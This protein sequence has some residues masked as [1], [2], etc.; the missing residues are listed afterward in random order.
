MREIPK[1]L[2]GEADSFSNDHLTYGS[3]TLR[4]E[5]WITAD[6]VTRTYQYLQSF[7]LRCRPRALSERNLA[8][9]R[10]VIRQLRDL[11]THGLK[12]DEELTKLA[13]RS[14]MGGWNKAHPEWAY[15]DERQ[16]YRDCRRIARAVAR[17][18][19]ATPS[20]KERYVSIPRRPV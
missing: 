16:F 4:V 17:P 14:V 9:T 1:C 18:F 3:I 20:S 5:P 13:W 15:D 8:M 2:E 7:M 10:F 11:I 19:N 6:T 12:D